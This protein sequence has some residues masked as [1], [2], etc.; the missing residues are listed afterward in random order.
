[1]RRLDAGIEER[2]PMRDRERA[3]SLEQQFRR[4]RCAPI[5]LVQADWPEMERKTGLRRAAQRTDRAAQAI[6]SDAVART[7]E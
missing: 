2:R 4:D 1:M 3:A 7:G 5:G 6:V